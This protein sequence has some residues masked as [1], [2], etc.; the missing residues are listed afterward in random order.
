MIIT[1]RENRIYKTVKSL[2]TKRGREESGLFVI[3]GAR[4]VVDAIKKNAQIE[5]IIKQD[6]VNIIEG[7][8]KE[9][10]FA[11]KLF[12]ELSDT[13]TPQG[14]MAVCKIP[15][16]KLSD[17]KGSE[18]SCVIMCEELQDPGNIGT[19]IRTAHAAFCDGVILTKGC[20]DLY[21]PKIVRSTMSGIFSVPVVCGVE[22]AQ[23]LSYFKNQGYESVAGALSDKAVDLY[24]SSLKEKKLIVV[25]N[26]GNG[27]KK[28]T[29]DLCDKV[30]KIPMKSDAESLNAAIAASVIIYEHYRQNTVNTL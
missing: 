5:Y 4:S 19:I 13:L 17:I 11:P 10:V 23:V 16:C 2:M 24:S 21:N 3:E 9:Y 12:C 15:S 6:G 8:F 1:S 20:C 22:S 29:L 14:I 18:K 25:G 7:S 30:V 28:E 27:I 26:E